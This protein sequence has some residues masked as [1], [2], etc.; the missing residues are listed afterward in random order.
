VRIAIGPACDSINPLLSDAVFRDKVVRCPLDAEQQ[1]GM[2]AI[3]CLALHYYF[4]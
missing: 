4:S 1:R 2:R 3:D